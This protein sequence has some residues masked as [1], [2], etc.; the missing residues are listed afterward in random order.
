MGSRPRISILMYHQ[1]GLFRRPAA[2]R[3]TFCHVRRFR[4]QMRWLKR[5][6]YHVISLTEALRGL[7]GEIPLPRHSVVLTFDDGYRN[8]YE[9]AYPVLRQCGFPATVFVVAGLMGSNARWIDEDG[10]QGAPLMEPGQLLEI[11]AGG[12]EI[13]SHTVSHP[14]LSRLAASEAQREIADSKAILESVLG[15][16]VVHF[17]YPYGDFD[18]RVADL[19]REAGYESGLTCIRGAATVEDSVFSLPRKAVS[20]GDSLIGYLW[21]LHIKNKKKNPSGAAKAPFM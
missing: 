6:G 5:S 10:R 7:K 1:V 21:K 2:H 20:Y 8:F 9:H 14:R 13:G 19:V 17:C 11:Q 18:R 12:I 3:A 15:T 4:A 16:P